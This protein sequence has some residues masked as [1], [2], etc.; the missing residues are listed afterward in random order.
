MTKRISLVIVLILS[1]LTLGGCASGGYVFTVLSNEQVL[2]S[3]Y[4]ELDEDVIT[5]GGYIYDDA[6]TEVLNTF[7]SIISNLIINFTD[8]DHGLT[9]LED[10]TIE[11]RILEDIGYA[12]VEDNVVKVTFVFESIAD[13]KLFYNYDES[14][15]SEP[16]VVIEDNIFFIKTTTVTSNYFN[17]ADT[18]SLATAFL[19][20]FNDGTTIFTLEDIDFTHTYATADTHLHSN[21]DRVYMYEGLKVH[22]W[23]IPN[24]N[25]SIEREFYEYSIVTVWWY[26]LALFLTFIFII[27]MIITHFG[28]TVYE[29]VSNK[30]QKEQDKEQFIARDKIRKDIEK[31]EGF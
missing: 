28:Q 1:I 4:I 18:S 11:Q 26:L 30:A 3:F 23:D 24:D 9:S 12:E 27:V 7:N 10:Y 15:A 19:D 17:G 25:Y 31:E 16:N 13:Y 8:V 6:E 29:S 2:E 20:Y 21:A 22:E 5:E 14:T